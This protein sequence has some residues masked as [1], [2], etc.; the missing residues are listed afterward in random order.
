MGYYHNQQPQNADKGPGCLD[1]IVI[2]RV[3]FGLLFWPVTALLLVMIDLG[4]ILYLF[5]VHPALALI[6]LSLTAVGLWLFGRWEQHH[7]RPPGLDDRDAGG[8]RR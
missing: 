4:A 3:V 5:A 2:T 6:P 1:A 8:F 7:I